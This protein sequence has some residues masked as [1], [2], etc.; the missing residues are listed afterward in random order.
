MKLIEAKVAGQPRI[1]ST[2]RGDRSVMDCR[3]SIFDGVATSRRCGINGQS[4]WGAGN[5]GSR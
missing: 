3:W 2:R 5:F 4:Q 1:V